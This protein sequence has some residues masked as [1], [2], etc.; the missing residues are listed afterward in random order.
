MASPLAA[1][2]NVLRHRKIAP[3]DPRILSQSLKRCAS[4]GTEPC[5][6]TIELNKR[7]QCRFVSERV[8][9]CVW[10]RPLPVPLNPDGINSY[11]GLLAGNNAGDMPLLLLM[12]EKYD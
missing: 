1:P 12:R 11:D 3:T 8:Q 6:E 7:S 4:I 10:V 2:M 9:L 5:R